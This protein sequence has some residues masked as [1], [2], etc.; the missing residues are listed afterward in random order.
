[1]DLDLEKRIAEAKKFWKDAPCKGG[2][3]GGR[4]VSKRGYKG[5]VCVLKDLHKTCPYGTI[6]NNYE[7]CNYVLEKT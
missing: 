4:T 5:L 1:M 7:V 6:I 3:I 2:A